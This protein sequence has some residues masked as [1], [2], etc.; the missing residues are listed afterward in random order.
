MLLLILLL[1]SPRGGATSDLSNLRPQDWNDRAVRAAVVNSLLGN[2]TAHEQKVLIAWTAVYANRFDVVRP[3]IRELFARTRK[4]S[5]A[6][7]FA[8]VFAAGI[9]DRYAAEPSRDLVDCFEESTGI[10]RTEAAI[11]IAAH[12]DAA[13]PDRLKDA[14]IETLIEQMRDATVPP[15]DRGRTIQAVE[16]FATDSERMTET[17]LDLSQPN[18]WFDGVH[19]AHYLESSIVNVIYA[20]GTRRTSPAVEERLRSLPNDIAASRLSK[21]D[22]WLA[23]VALEWVQK[24]SVNTAPG[25]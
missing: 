22:Q 17:L 6:R 25:H 13:L 14:V 19:G 12:S 4:K 10:L 1:L 8:T 16:Y 24:H 2:S 7:D 11:A 20:L 23:T 9:D 3:A 15:D 5:E 21:F 18:R